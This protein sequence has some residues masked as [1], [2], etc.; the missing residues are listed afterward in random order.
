MKQGL[1]FLGLTLGG[2]T[3]NVNAQQCDLSIT[4]TVPE[5]LAW[6]SWSFPPMTRSYRPPAG[7]TP[8]A[9]V[10][11]ISKSSAAIAPTTPST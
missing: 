3:L 2:L 8:C 6:I 1:V 5:G 4:G 9:P 7:T 10:S 11:K